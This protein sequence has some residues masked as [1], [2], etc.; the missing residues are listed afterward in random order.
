M[1]HMAASP[2][3][4][5]QRLSPVW[6]VL[7][8]LLVGMMMFAPGGCATWSMP[9]DVDDADLR[10]RAVSKTAA[11]VR[12]SASVLGSG[13]SKRLFGTDVNSSGIQPVWVEVEN[14]GPDSLWLLRAGTDPDYFSPLEAAW[15]FHT[16]LARKR[17]SA[18][19]K[20]FGALDFSNP[21]P[22]HSTRSGV[23][24]TNPHERIRLLNID[25]LGPGRV[26]PF[27]L[28]LPDP[29]NPPDESIPEL[30]ARD[31]ETAPLD[32][33][34]TDTLRKKLK[35]APCCAKSAGQGVTGDP[36]NVVLI[37]TIDDVAA[38]MVRRGFR[39]DRRELDNTQRLFGRLPDVVLRKSGK[40]DVPA[41]WIR[42]WLAPFRYRSEPVW[43]GQAGRPVG[44]RFAVAS[45]RILERHPDVDEVR[46][47]LI[48]DLIYSGGMAKL[49]FVGGAGT[50]ETARSTGAATDSRYSTDGLRAVMFF[51]S[52]PRAI[53][54][55]EI[56]DWDPVLKRREA[57]ATRE[58]ANE[59]PR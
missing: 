8:P 38:A 1:N 42:A 18:I 10:E 19:D 12:L 9:E 57:D 58:H 16:P 33:R 49:G 21:I 40:G 7:V 53:S 52:R 6:R 50:V 48:Q 26:I 24:F 30:V 17:N 20:H 32:I 47:L 15:L 37:G 45:D 41:Q 54:D 28:F 22:A 23:I 46:N 35:D 3:P 31:S 36:I 25:L 5:W 43:L 44:G 27:T 14:S 39:T 2:A 59:F 13:D 4:R 55:V 11:D 34:N 29:D 56:L 51:L